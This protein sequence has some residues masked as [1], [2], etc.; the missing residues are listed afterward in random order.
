MR[1]S[2]WMIVLVLFAVPVWADSLQFT[3]TIFQGQGSLSFIPGI[4]NAVTIGAGNGANGA[5][6]TDFVNT[7]AVC[8]GDCA[9]T[10]GYMTLTSGPETSGFAGGGAFTYAFGSGGTVD[11]YGEIPSLSITGSSLLFSASFLSGGIFTGAGTVGSFIGQLDLGSIFLNPTLGT[12]NYTDGSTNE[13]SISL[14]PGCGTGGSCNG[15]IFNSATT[16]QASAVPEPSSLFLL[17]IGLSGLAGM[18][19]R[20]L[21]A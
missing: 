19:R 7:S 6:V 2:L 14:N 17:G 9:I 18:I 5:L 13:I 10:G 3:G 12:Y 16:L 21:R 1:K 11:I 15:S 4:G 20:K 8:T